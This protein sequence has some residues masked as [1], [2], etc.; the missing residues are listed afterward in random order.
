M[1]V[2]RSALKKRAQPRTW[3]QRS[4]WMP[5]GVGAQVQELASIRRRRRGR[6][7]GRRAMC[8]SPRVGELEFGARA[9]IRTVDQQHGWAQCATAAAA[10]SSIRRPSRKRSMRERRVDRVRLVAGHGPRQQVPGARRRLEAAG[11]P[12]AVDVQARHRRLADDRRAVG[13]H[14]DDA[15]P[16]AQH[17]H[18]TERR[19]QFADRR[20]ACAS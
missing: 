17:A 18:A 1:T 12:A 9:A 4:A 11:A 19:E 3:R 7:I 8:A 10:A 14:V 2:S 20:R 15:A 6:G 5:S 13:R 16:V